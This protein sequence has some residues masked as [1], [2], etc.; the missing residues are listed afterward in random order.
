VVNWQRQ[1]EEAQRVV[2][3]LRS[4]QKSVKASQKR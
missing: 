3:E 4:K 1:A 2:A